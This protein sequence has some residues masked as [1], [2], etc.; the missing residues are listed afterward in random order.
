MTP[1]KQLDQ[2]LDRE[3]QP[4]PSEERPARERTVRV[5]T[6]VRAGC[7]GMTQIDPPS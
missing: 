7:G 1:K 4:P 5:R 2:V 6:K 3:Q